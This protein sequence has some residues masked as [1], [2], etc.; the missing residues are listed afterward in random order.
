MEGGGG[1]I[2][3]SITG[4]EEGVIQEGVLYYVLR[5]AMFTSDEPKKSADLIERHSRQLQLSSRGQEK[6]ERKSIL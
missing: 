1:E 4:K 2:R 6:D 3:D 5:S